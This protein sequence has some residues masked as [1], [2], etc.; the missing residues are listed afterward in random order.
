MTKRKTMKPTTRPALGKCLAAISVCLLVSLPGVAFAEEGGS[1]SQDINVIQGIRRGPEGV[2]VEVTSSR[3]FPV[4]A[5]PPVLQVGSREF[6]RSLRP[7]DGDLDTLIFLLEHR[8]YARL[9]SGEPTYVV[10][11]RGES[12]RERWDFG[13]FRK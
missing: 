11:G 2:E 5:I 6:S 12:P 9:R 1:V 8:E 4:R 7:A 10:Y 3:A 13:G